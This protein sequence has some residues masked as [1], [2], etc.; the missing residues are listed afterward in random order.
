VLSTSS[1][2]NFCR[3][4]LQ[5]CSFDAADVCV[6]GLLIWRSFMQVVLTAGGMLI[7]AQRNRASCWDFRVV[8]TARLAAAYNR[9]GLPFDAGPRTSRP[10]C[11]KLYLSAGIYAWLARRAGPRIGPARASVSVNSSIY[12][13]ARP[14]DE[15]KG[16]LGGCGEG[17][18]GRTAPRTM[19]DLATARDAA[20]Q[21]GSATC[22][23]AVELYTSVALRAF[24][25][26]RGA[27]F[28]S[29]S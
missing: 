3:D 14:A 25:L 19:V 24:W 22:N 2:H 20:S 23:R 4:R 29:I 13:L 11:P 7:S 21:T 17:E 16:L 12:K 1:L 5:R 9:K 18:G 26:A 28:R 27:A 8:R 15:A 10:S 6:S